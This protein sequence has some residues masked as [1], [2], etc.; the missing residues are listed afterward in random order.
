MESELVAPQR[1]VLNAENSVAHRSVRK[2]QRWWAPGCANAKVSPKI[3]PFLTPVATDSAAMRS[4]V[5]SPYCAAMDQ[6]ERPCAREHPIDGMN[7]LVC[8]AEIA[9]KRQRSSWSD[10]G[11]AAFD[12]ELDA[13][14]VATFV[15]SKEGN[16][17]GNFVQGSRATERF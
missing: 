6:C 4:S 7:A 16:D 12:E 14:H 10:L 9:S 2:Q 5:S 8:G 17:F 13:R 15:G 11:H 1:E 3:R